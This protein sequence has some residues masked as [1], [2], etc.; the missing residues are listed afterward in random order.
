[1]DHPLDFAANT[2]PDILYSH[3]AIKALDRQKYNDAISAELYQRET[4]GYFV[5]MK[6]E[7]IT[8]GNK[9]I[10]MGWSMRRE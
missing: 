2:N 5:P 9:L 6:K 1:M 4:R 3:E 7:D 10:D 8:P